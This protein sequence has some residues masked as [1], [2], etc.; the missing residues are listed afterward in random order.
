MSGMS[1]CARLNESACVYL[2]AAVFVLFCESKARHILTNTTSKE[3]KEREKQE[4]D[5]ES[6]L[7]FLFSRTVTPQSEMQNT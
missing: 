5:A 3:P 6:E 7:C 2:Y 4:Q 1:E